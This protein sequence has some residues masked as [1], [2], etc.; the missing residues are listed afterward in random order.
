MP[1]G[2]HAALSPRSANLSTI[3]VS[4]LGARL[5]LRARF[6]PTIS[7]RRGEPPNCEGRPSSRT[8]HRPASYRHVLPPRFSLRQARR[9]IAAVTPRHARAVASSDPQAPEIGI[10]D[11][12]AGR[13]R[14]A[15]RTPRERRHATGGEW[16]PVHAVSARRSIQYVRIVDRVADR[17]V[18]NPDVNGGAAIVRRAPAR[19][20][21]DSGV[22]PAAGS[23]RIR[24]PT[25]MPARALQ[26]A[27]YRARAMHGRSVPKSF[28][29]RRRAAP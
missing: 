18:G 12:G 3:N 26:R 17:L 7:L 27:P 14:S 19:P 23:S 21:R 20:R 11:R 13:R 16:W 28:T 4:D 5:S 15:R 22:V 2:L 24:E 8:S 1:R 29:R 25:D 10:V 9:A 6:C